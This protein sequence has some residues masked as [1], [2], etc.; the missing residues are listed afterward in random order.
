M[1]VVKSNGVF[2]VIHYRELNPADPNTVPIFE[3]SAGEPIKTVIPNLFSKLKLSQQSKDF[4]I[5]TS[6]VPI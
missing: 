2:I 5:R 6:G 1:P 3:I 4:Q